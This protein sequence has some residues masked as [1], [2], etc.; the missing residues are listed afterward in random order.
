LYESKLI[1]DSF[2]PSTCKTGIGRLK[3]LALQ[4]KAKV[5]LLSSISKTKEMDGGFGT[6]LCAEFLSRNPGAFLAK[7]QL[8]SLK[9]TV[10]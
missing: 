4:L 10:V 7:T 2:T 8:C 5:A 3:Q 6:T 1:A 9:M